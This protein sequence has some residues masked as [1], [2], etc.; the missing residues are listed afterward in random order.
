MTLFENFTPWAFFVDFGLISILLLIGQLLRAKI[1]LIQRMF[2][3]PSLIAGVLGLALGPNG[4]GWLPFSNELGT[5]ASILIAIVFSALPFSTASAPMKEVVRTAGPMWAFAQ[6]GMLL[7]WGIVGLLG[8]FVLKAIWPNLHDAFGIMFPT[9]FYGGH[10]TAAAIGSAFEGLNWED[11]RS[12]GMMTATIGVICAIG[13]GLILIKWAT[14]H[15]QTALI[16]DFSELPDELRSG[17]VPDDRRSSIGQATTS[18]ISIDSLT[19]H[20]ALV[21][22]AA[23]LGYLCSRGIKYLFPMLELPVFSCA[24]VIGLIMKRLF[25]VTRVSKYICPQTTI[26]I[27]NMS[28]DLLVAFGVASIKMSVIVKY[29]LPLTILVVCGTAIT[30]LITFYFG[31]KLSKNYWFER[32]IF[33]WGW[34][35]GTMAMGIALLRIVDPKLSSKTM[36][37]YALAYLPIAPL[38]IAL[39]TFAPIMFANGMGVWLLVGCLA[40]SA[41][42]ILIAWLMKWFVP[43]KT[44]N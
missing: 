35:T 42:T 24:F 38:E 26:R 22:V 37:D 34:W 8:L 40:L 23:L 31:K 21:C 36:D 39:I 32:T 15:N 29:A 18:S 1:S 9:G 43:S 2:I 28:T 30:L 27:G 17:L 25:D 10:G 16:K 12:L 19:Y 33:A 14:R 6:L 11:A 13:G 20:F 5:Y 7:Q 41:L 4:L 44:E 3:P